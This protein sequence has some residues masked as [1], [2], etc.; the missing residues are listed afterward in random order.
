MAKFLRGID[1][2]LTELNYNLLL[3]TTHRHRGNELRYAATIMRSGVDG[4]LLIVPLMSTPYLDTLDE[5]DFPYVVIDQSDKTQKGSV[6]SGTNWQG[7]YEATQYL[8]L[9]ATGT[10]SY[11]IHFGSGGIEQRRRTSGRVCLRFV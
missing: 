4:L 10:S 11:R 7:A 1:E 3:Y 2:A 5:Q 8:E 9:F 6:V